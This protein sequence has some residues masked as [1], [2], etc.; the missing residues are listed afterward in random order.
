MILEI[1]QLIAVAWFITQGQ[2]WLDEINEVLKNKKH[3][4]RLPFIISSCW[5]CISFWLTLLV[6]R[7]FVLACEVSMIA[8]LIDANLNRIRL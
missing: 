4:L 6:T 1:F 3:I 2:N 5:R 8:H 7:D